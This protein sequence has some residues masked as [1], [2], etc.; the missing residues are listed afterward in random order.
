M[1]EQAEPLQELRLQ[2]SH[3]LGS[4]RTVREM[5]WRLAATPAAALCCGAQGMPG[6]EPTGQLHS[7]PSL[8]PS[9]SSFSPS[10]ELSLAPQENILCAAGWEGEYYTHMCM[11][12]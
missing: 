11:C 1:L 4:P 2:R 10:L 8:R 12:A 6:R 7:G 9:R 5:S 3:S